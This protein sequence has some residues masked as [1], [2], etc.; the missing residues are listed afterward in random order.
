M[1]Q[2]QTDVENIDL[3]IPRTIDACFPTPTV[4]WF[5][6][7]EVISNTSVR[8]PESMGG[9]LRNDILIKNLGRQDLHSQ[10][11]CSAQNSNLTAPTESVVHVDMNFGPLDVRIL[12]DSQPLSAGRRYDL[13]CQSSGSRPPASITWW[14]N[15]QR[16]EKTKETTS[17]DGNTTTS[18]LSFNAS[19]EDAGKYLSC[20][21]EN[22]VISSDGLEDGWKL[23][24]Q[25]VPEA[26]LQLGTSLKP[27]TI[28]EGTDV[29][30]DCLIKAQPNVYKVEWRHNGRL[31]SH[32]TAQGIIISNQSLVLQ[33][34]SRS[35]AGNYTCV[36]Y[37]AEGDGESKPFYLNVMYAPTCKP[38]QSRI[39]GI[40][41]QEKANISCEVEAN[42]PQVTFR[43]TFNNSAESLDVSAAHISRNG[44]TSFVSYT[45]MTELDYGTLLCWASNRI[46]HQRVPCA[47]H[48]IAAGRPDQVHNCSVAN[49]SMTSFSLRCSEGFNGGLPQSFFLEVRE[50][51]SQV[52]QANVTSQVPRFSVAGL[53]PGAQ[54]QAC[55][56]SFNMKGRSEPV[57]VQAATLRLPEKQHTLDKERPKAA[58]R[59]TP[60]M[61]VLIGAVSALL[62]VA[63]VVVV[64]LRVQCSRNEDRRKRHKAAAAAHEQRCSASGG[65]SGMDKNS[66]SPINKLDPGGTE[67]G[68]SDEKNPDIIPQPTAVDQEDHTDYLRKRQ[69]ISTIETSPSRGLL[70][71]SLQNPVAGVYAGYCTLRNGMPLQDL[72]NIGSKGK[73]NSGEPAGYPTLPRQHWPSYGGVR[74][75]IPPPSVVPV[76]PGMCASYPGHLHHPLPSPAGVVVDKQPLINRP[77]L[78]VSGVVAEDELATAETPLMVTKRESTV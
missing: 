44:T 20:R 14:R 4:T 11:K 41:K 63:V 67:S 52:L 35:S 59:F 47:F 58:L 49:S 61:S 33:G 54:Y 77:P 2:L 55:V 24:I 9:Q 46:G 34:V 31:L 66:G 15:G 1:Q 5:R 19:K 32:N 78:A 29:Y 75:H 57:P 60:M 13:L 69:H 12:G 43:W 36:G 70:Q 40:A 64:V 71:Q 53:E 25:Y 10:L 73:I 17:N 68:D 45:P 56:Y 23:E 26:R 37:N 39:H 51:H 6:N 27:D 50:S 62:I 42:P 76:V 38:N 74:H 28:R 72:N 48:I 65:V 16:L 21:A 22:P 18:T 7:D 30:F 8:M 3:G